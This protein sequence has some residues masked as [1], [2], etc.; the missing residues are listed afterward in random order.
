MEV[1]VL[2]HT[3]AV[4]E[5]HSVVELLKV[6]PQQHSDRLGQALKF[7]AFFGNV[8]PTFSGETAYFSHFSLVFIRYKELNI[9]SCKWVLHIPLEWIL[10]VLFTF[11]YLYTAS[12]TCW[13][14]SSI[15]VILKTSA[16]RR[17]LGSV[18]EDSK[19]HLR[20]R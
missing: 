20:Q 8:E 9:N 7:F 14:C 3:S 2:S 16:A 18:C 1:K 5:R 12:L 15:N 11:I 4:Q 17:S 13:H 6:L 10:Q 19:K